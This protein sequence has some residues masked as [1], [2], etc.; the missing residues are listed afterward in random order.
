MKPTH[1]IS[2]FGG[3]IKAKFFNARIPLAVSWSLTFRCNQRCLYCKIWQIQCPEIGTS[4][5]LAMLD[6]FKLLGTRWISFTGGEPLLRDDIGEIVK[7]TKNKDIYVSVSSNGSLVSERIG[8]LTGIDR[9]KLSL[10]GPEKIHDR[11]RGGGS[12]KKVMQAL[13]LCKKNGIGVRL[14]CVLSKENLDC[15]PYLVNIASD[16]EVIISFQPAT[17]NLLWSDEPNLIAASQKEYR[18]A[19]NELISLKKRGAPVY[20]STAGLSH[21]YW[22][23]AEKRIACTAGR[24]SFDVEPDGTILACDRFLRKIKRKKAKI[25]DI[26]RELP[27]LPSAGKC[28]QC[29]CS[30]LVELNLI[31]SF[32][33]NAVMNYFRTY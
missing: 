4:E 29:W 16:F 22:W 23:P 6:N 12:F 5:I 3:L 7:Y 20:N 9:I 21:L 24:L 31:T 10:D 32:N 27:D 17:R 1:I 28:R 13:E 15:V 18:D 25:T 8:D 30:S 14:E 26:K 33:V 19:I 2:A 11:V